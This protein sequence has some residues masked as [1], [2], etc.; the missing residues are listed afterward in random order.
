MPKYHFDIPEVHYQAVEV[1]ASSPEE[2][3]DKI[4]NGNY[5]EQGEP[6]YQYTLEDGIQWLPENVRKES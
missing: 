2:A 6:Q 4:K 5:T 3:I 1:E